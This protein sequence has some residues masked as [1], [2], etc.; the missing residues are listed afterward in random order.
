MP[1]PTTH[2][3]RVGTTLLLGAALIVPTA[4][5]AFA[6]PALD[7]HPAA[8][9]DAADPSWAASP[10]SQE[11]SASATAGTALGTN[12]A[13]ADQQAPAV[14]PRVADALAMEASYQSFGARGSQP[15]LTSAAITP[16]DGTDPWLLVGL[17][18]TGVLVAGGSVATV[19]RHR[20]RVTRVLA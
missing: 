20:H 8:A 10:R 11:N 9:A 16:D 18:L 13:A 6:Q 3:R 17:S 12:V 15:A 1:A 4:G 19:R 2:R 5:T 14:S 7:A